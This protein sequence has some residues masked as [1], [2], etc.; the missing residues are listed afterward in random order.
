M[1]LNEHELHI[2]NYK[3]RNRVVTNQIKSPLEAESPFH[4]WN[5]ALTTNGHNEGNKTNN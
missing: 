1:N 5:L 3:Q 4:M 2:T